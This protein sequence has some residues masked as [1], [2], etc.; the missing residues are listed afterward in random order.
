[1]PVD[2]GGAGGSSEVPQDAGG[3]ADP[4]ADLVDAE[5]PATA[6]VETSDA[7]GD[8][9]GAIAE[10]LDAA[11]GTDAGAP[12]VGDPCSLTVTVTTATAGGTY[13][14][15]NIGAIWIADVNDKFVKSLNVWA[16]RRIEHLEQWR[17]V[18]FSAGTQDNR[19]DAITSATAP[20]HGTK[21]ARWDCKNAARALVPDGTYRVCF[22]MT[23]GNAAGPLECIRFSKG[24]AA[25]TI[26]PRDTANFKQ[27]TLVFTP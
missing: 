23:E 26:A 18:T 8:D 4:G 12:A 1:V 3:S 14:P 11:L 20:M 7:A 25:Q 21:T 22:E 17:W 27:R 10:P 2:P 19:V 15:E 24:P 6:D 9:D 13:A 5:A 16:D